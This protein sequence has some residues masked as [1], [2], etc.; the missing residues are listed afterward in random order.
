M[1]TSWPLACT[2]IMFSYYH[3]A[4]RTEFF[5]EPELSAK[6]IRQSTCSCHLACVMLINFDAGTQL[7]SFKASSGEYVNGEGTFD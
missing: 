7:L 3:K 2:Q 5:R 4:V 6:D 1:F